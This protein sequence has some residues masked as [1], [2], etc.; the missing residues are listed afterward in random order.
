MTPVDPPRR[1][2]GQ[3]KRIKRPWWVAQRNVINP[4]DAGESTLTTVA[5]GFKSYPHHPS[6]LTRE[7]GDSYRRFGDKTDMLSCT[8]VSTDR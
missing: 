6:H 5:H 3:R 8:F 2:A 1:V 7:I 4:L